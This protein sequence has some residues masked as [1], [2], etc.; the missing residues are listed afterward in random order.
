MQPLN[1][2][3]ALCKCSTFPNNPQLACTFAAGNTALT[4]LEA[5]YRCEN[6]KSPGS[7]ITS[8][9][10]ESAELL[11]NYRTNNSEEKE[12]SA[13]YV[14]ERTCP[15]QQQVVNVSLMTQFNFAACSAVSVCQSTWLTKM[16]S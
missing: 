13:E 2:H 14:E 4:S 7:R 5:Y 1:L 11:E 16:R 10:V 8:V 12:T 3:A 6:V 9:P 15:R